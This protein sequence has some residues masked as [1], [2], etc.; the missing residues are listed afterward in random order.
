[1]CKIYQLVTNKLN[2]TRSHGAQLPVCQEHKREKTRLSLQRCNCDN[3]Q[4]FSPQNGCKVVKKIMPCSLAF[5]TYLTWLLAGLLKWIACL[6][7]Q[8]GVQWAKI[9]EGRQ[10]VLY[11]CVASYGCQVKTTRNKNKSQFLRFSSEES[12]WSS[13]PI[14]KIWHVLVGNLLALLKKWTIV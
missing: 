9:C 14:E 11:T 8:H 6:Q 2:L 1:M 3:A 12:M 7:L 4:S 10:D 5:W 13:C